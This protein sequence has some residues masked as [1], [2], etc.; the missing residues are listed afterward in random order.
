MDLQ[1]LQMS[2]PGFLPEIIYLCLWEPGGDDKSETGWVQYK[3]QWW[4]WGHLDTKCPTYSCCPA[5]ATWCL[6]GMPASHSQVHNF[7]KTVWNSDIC[8]N[9][10]FVNVG[11]LYIFLSLNTM[12]ASSLGSHCN[13]H[14]RDSQEEVRCAT[15]CFYRLPQELHLSALSHS[16]GCLKKHHPFHWK[17]MSLGK[18]KS[19]SF[20]DPDPALPSGL[21]IDP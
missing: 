3:T 16:G 6:E 2:S 21:W 5:P 20:K 19:R 7:S 10:L 12:Q 9:I 8:A 14:F 4:H 17:G 13:I 11:S 18:V 15:V 1:S